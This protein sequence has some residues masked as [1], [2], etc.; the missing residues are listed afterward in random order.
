MNRFF[1]FLEAHFLFVSFYKKKLCLSFQH[2]AIYFFVFFFPFS[3]VKTKNTVLHSY[4][5]SH[6]SNEGVCHPQYIWR[7]HL[8]PFH[9]SSHC[10]I[11][12]KHPEPRIN[13]PQRLS[14]VTHCRS[15]AASVSSPSPAVCCFSSAAAPSEGFKPV[16][17]IKQQ[18][19]KLC[20]QTPK[21]VSS[22]RSRITSDWKKKKRREG[23]C[24]TKPLPPAQRRR[25]EIKKWGSFSDAASK[26]F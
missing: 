8:P 4:A 17:A 9:I 3:P 18:K 1:F 16:V 6:A 21:R 7:A 22:C 10:Q 11:G 23:F 5:R 15:N 20:E 19:S 14:L 13:S 2:V 12:T 26:T 25:M 24:N